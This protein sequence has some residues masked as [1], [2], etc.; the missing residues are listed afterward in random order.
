[1]KNKIVYL[2]ATVFLAVSLFSPMAAFAATSEDVTSAAASS[3][4]ST[5]SASEETLNK[6]A[7]ETDTD[8][9]LSGKKGSEKD[10]LPRSDEQ[11]PK[12]NDAEKTT[13]TNGE[14][15][16]SNVKSYYAKNIGLADVTLLQDSFYYDGMPKTPEVSVSYYGD[17]LTKDKDYYIEYQNNTDA[18]EASVTVRGKGDYSGSTT[19]YFYIYYDEN[20]IAVTLEH[21]SYTYDEKP[22]KPDVTVRLKS[23]G[24][25][26]TD[27]CR[28]SYSNNLNAGTAYVIAK[29]KKYYKYDDD[30]Y[31]DDMTGVYFKSNVEKAFTIKP[32]KITSCSLTNDRY[33]YN[34]KRKT[35]TIIDFS[36]CCWI[37]YYKKNKDYTAKYLTNCTSIGKHKVRYT[38]KGNY[39][40]SVTK[41][42]KILP[43]APKVKSKN[44]KGKS[45]TI[46][47]KKVKGA[48]GY[49]V[50]KDGKLY[51]TTKKTSIRLT[52]KKNKSY[53]SYYVE[54]YKKNL[55]TSW[56][57]SGHNAVFGQP[58]TSI[59]LSRPD[60]GEIKVKIKNYDNQYYHNYQ[61][62]V[63]NNKKFSNKGRNYVT[64]S[65]RSNY[66]Y[67]TFTWTGFSSGERGYFRVRQYWYTSS[68]KLKVGKWSAVKSIK[69]Y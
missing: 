54:S 61:F 8:K 29:S 7:G 38:F 26:I 32:L 6:V 69:A 46:Y 53:I 4:A 36:D 45:V 62:Q 18:G 3:A 64:S 16:S 66:Y 21:N 40:G 24:N 48:T 49:K 34:G 37:Y 20:D 12:N 41:S 14:A 25:D 19:E 17:K 42:F 5:S 44:K 1:M 23:T 68:G 28:I 67:K 9:Q 57:S 31:N 59:S 50:Y 56:N 55:G 33:H 60:W 22:I 30:F 13:V 58:R 11:K 15:T 47:W 65:K 10:L 63:S 27:E 39:T 2:I 35:P 51:K 43:S 52:A